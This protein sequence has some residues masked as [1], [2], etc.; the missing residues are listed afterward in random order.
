[1]LPYN[2][3]P[4]VCALPPTTRVIHGTA[5]KP[6]ALEAGIVTV[7]PSIRFHTIC[8]VLKF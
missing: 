8:S 6:R 4:I 3:S 5:P 2:F 7:P 1:M